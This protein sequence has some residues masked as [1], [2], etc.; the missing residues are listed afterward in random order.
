MFQH[1]ITFKYAA[2]VVWAVRDP[3]RARIIKLI[4]EGHST[5][6]EHQPD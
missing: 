4:V 3:E 5:A 2:A 6:G 1:M